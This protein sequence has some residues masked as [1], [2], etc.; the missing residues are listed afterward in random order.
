MALDQRYDAV[1]AE[2]AL[3]KQWAAEDIYNPQHNPGERFTIDT[4][5]PTVSGA[6]H[7]G[8]IFSYTQTDIIARYKRMQ[9]YSVVY[10]FGFDD[11][12]LPTERF[13]EKKA[14]IR[15]HQVGRS[16]FIKICLEQTQAV[17]VLFKT[18]WQRMGLSVNWEYEYS[19]IADNVRRIS[20]ASFLNLL[21][22]DF[23]YRTNEPALY[24]TECRTSVAQAELDDAEV[25]SLFNELIFT[26]AHNNQIIITTTRP[27]L[28][29]ACVAVM[30]HPT[31]SR[32]AH[33]IGTHITV[34]Y[35]NF[36]V[37][38]I[39]D[40]LVKQDKGTG[41]VMCCT[42]GDNLDIIW[43]KKHA[44][45][46]KS[47]IGLDGKMTAL[48]GELAGLK[49]A[50]ARIRIIE[51]LKQKNI[52]VTQKPIVHAVGIH[53]RCKKE[54]EYTVLPQWFVAIL[55]Y[56]QE[57]IA[58]ADQIE[59]YPAFM[60]TRYI[61]WVENLGWDWCISRQR[62][63]GIP[64]PVW[65]CTTCLAIIP[66]HIDQL[67]IDPQEIAHEGLCPRCHN[68]TVIADTD[69]MD[70]WNT[71][72]LTP[73]IIYELV[74]QKQVTFTDLD[75]GTDGFLPMSMHP[76]AHDIIRTWAF[77]TMARVWMHHGTIPWKNIVI[78]GHVLSDQKDKLSKS[79]DNAALTPDHLL[80]QYSAD[81][82]RY[83]T[84]SGALGYDVVFSD[85]QL[86]IGQKIG[87]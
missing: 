80:N 20:Q 44:L 52:L 84:A 47:A 38:V 87:H 74:S 62:L 40:E 7:I 14:G 73:Y 46:F 23:V 42:F 60:K 43:Y 63:Y 41:A 55:K 81:V 69:I 59:W 78:S 24:C 70:T 66:A 16:A 31:D 39:A 11:N 30:V 53:E 29:P 12:G 50:E 56:K 86:K 85:N 51:L 76:Q 83:W 45:P 64:F 1:S 2:I 54:I 10:P 25:P 22:K 57:L 32:Y 18:L 61:N 34:P 8:H 71:S 3:Q 27:E 4:P 58:L 79:K 48:A 26:D 75:K 21:Q 35:F 13:V 82:I 68:N 19:T 67:P 15:A 37:P 5:P 36:T 28:L 6:L 77:Y 33:L 17:E 9:E 72:A 49:V 65:H